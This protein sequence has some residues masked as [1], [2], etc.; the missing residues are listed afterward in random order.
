MQNRMRST[1]RLLSAFCLI[2]AASYLALPGQTPATAPSIKLSGYIRTDFIYD[3]RQS[4]SSNGLREG[5][6]YLYPDN[7][8][9]DADSVDLNAHPSFHILNIQTRLK[10]DFTGPDAFGAK[11]TGVIEAEFFGTSEADLNGFR[12]RLAYTRLE[13]SKWSLLL[14][15]AW[16]PMFPTECF[17]QT[18]SFNTGAPFVP[19]SRN[20]QLRLN[21]SPGPLSLSF[22]AYAERD[23]TSTGPDGVSN[24]YMRNAGFPS[25]DLQTRIPIF[26]K[27]LFIIGADYKTIRP[28][29]K[30]SLNHENPNLL[31]SFSAFATFHVKTKPVNFSLMGSLCRNAHDLLMIGGYG[32]KEITSDITGVRTFAN[33]TTASAWMDVYTTGSRFQAGLFAGYTRNLGASGELAGPLYARGSNIGY[34]YRLSP[35]ILITREKLTIAGEIESTVAGYGT[36][37]S[38]GTVI[39]THR[40]TNHRILVAVIYKF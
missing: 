15:Q 13:W 4:S 12:L 39:D 40:V 23:F 27:G 6:F 8:L 21:Y 20:P 19:F 14:G 16:H 37:T 2:S 22:T 3:T 28:E 38:T 24:K 29:L 34:V 36:T 1:V 7:V 5:H 30:T 9:Y 35:R 25:F 18:L 26:T 17:P 31:G 11:T 32:V 10:G 33:L